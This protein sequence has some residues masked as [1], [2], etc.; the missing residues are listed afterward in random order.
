MSG[1]KQ[2]GK[3]TLVKHLVRLLPNTEVIAFADTLKQVVLDCFVPEYLGFLS[4]A[5]LDLEENKMTMLP[6]G[7]T[8]RQVLQIVGTD[9]FRRLFPDCWVNAYRKKVFRSKA[10]FILTPDV[11]FPNEL[12]TIQSLGG[13][14]IRLL[15]DPLK[16]KHQ[17]ETALDLAE[18]AFL[19]HW[20][21]LAFAPEKVLF[22]QGFVAFWNLSRWKRQSSP[23]F[24]FVLDNREMTI[25]EQ[26]TWTQRWVENHVSFERTSGLIEN[27]QIFKSEKTCPCCCLNGVK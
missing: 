4:V 25:E 9:W 3:T 7:K 19:K 22:Q 21:V 12:K 5:D 8:V 11:R 16:D 18:Q 20:P 24:D 23:R 17:S 1:K 15:R 14:T 13:K 2:G 10:S 27:P 6:C 26:N